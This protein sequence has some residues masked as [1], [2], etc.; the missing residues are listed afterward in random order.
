MKCLKASHY[1]QRE[2]IQAFCKGGNQCC[3]I[4]H[5]VLEGVV[6]LPPLLKIIFGRQDLFDI[7]Q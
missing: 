4:I 6:P 3:L 1:E 7:L 5:F 2:V